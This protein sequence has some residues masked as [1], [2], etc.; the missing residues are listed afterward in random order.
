MILWCFIC[1][2]FLVFW[3]VVVGFFWF[4]GVFVRFYKLGVIMDKLLL[5]GL[6]IIFMIYD[7]AY[8]QV[9]IIHSSVYLYLSKYY[10]VLCLCV[11]PPSLS[12]FLSLS[13]LSVYLKC[14]KVLSWGLSLY[15][16]IFLINEKWAF[17]LHFDARN[18]CWFVR[19]VNF[20]YIIFIN[21]SV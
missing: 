4:T 21:C 1:I 10:T 14:K 8:F 7:D 11:L 5:M 6:F 19:S 15:S 9:S 12:L 16:L 18:L 17:W 2:I 20:V 3:F 13:S